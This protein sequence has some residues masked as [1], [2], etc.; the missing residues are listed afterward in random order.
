M[1]PERLQDFVFFNCHG[2]QTFILYEIH[3][4]LSP[5]KSCHNNSF[6]SLF[7][8]PPSRVFGPGGETVNPTGLM[9]NMGI[10]NPNYN[11]NMLQI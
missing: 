5:L 1:S 8:F 4:Y 3:C 9:I 2:F 6:F 7:P 10:Q 11:M